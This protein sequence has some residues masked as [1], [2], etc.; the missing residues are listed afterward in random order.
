MAGFMIC[1]AMME[2]RRVFLPQA[3][4]AFGYVRVSVDEVER[5]AAQD[6]PIGRLIEP[7]EVADLVL[8]LV[9]DRAS[10]ITGQTI[11]IEGG[12]G[13]GIHY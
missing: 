5:R 11:G 12:A 3:N 4:R 1:S 8:F 9:S 10:A 2:N 7:E 13:R 6:T